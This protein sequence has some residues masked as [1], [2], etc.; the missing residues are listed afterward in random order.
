MSHMPAADTAVLTL[1]GDSLGIVAL[2]RFAA[3]AT[4]LALSDA[5]W[6]RIAEARAVVDRI[7]EAGVPAYGIT[8]GFGSQKDFAVDPRRDAAF[9]LAVLTGHATRAPGRRAP[10]AVIR[11]ALAVQLNGWARGWSGVRPAL[12]A[13]QLARANA[14]V[15]PDVRTGSSVGASDIVALSQLALPLVG[16]ASDGPAIDALASGVPPLDGLAAKEAMSLLNSNALTL[17]A[18]AL[19]LAEVRRLL[20]ALDLAAALSLE[21]FRGNPGAWSETVERAH[22]QAGHAASGQALRRLL[23]DSALWQPGAPRLL[24]DPLSLRCAPQIHG[25]A[26]T[27]LAWA[28]E[29]WEAALNAVADNPLVDRATGAAVSHG[30]METTLLAV[31]LDA[32]RLAVAKAVEASGERVHKLQWPSFSGLPAGLAAESGAAGGVQFLNLGHIAAAK[33]AAARIAA[34]PVALQYRGQVCDGVEDV[35]GMAPFAVEETERQLDA[36]WTAVTVEAVVAVWAIARRDLPVDGLGL[37]LRDPW[38]A[39][40]PMLPIGREG[41]VPFDLAPLETWL[42]AW[43]PPPPC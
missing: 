39:L 43:E 35:G 16:R 5:A 2:A 14:G 28:W 34:Q 31:A 18:G 15:A 11:A 9:N 40:R 32:L 42:R 6:D 12:C 1:D 38:R 33:V 7:V 21:G 37:G 25:A 20:D 24:Q 41:E 29:A 27:A 4:R 26:R 10:A 17:A 8:T 36:A 13:A 3:G 19:A 23:A 22:P 30:S